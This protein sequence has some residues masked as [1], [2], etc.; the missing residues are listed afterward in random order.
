LTDSLGIDIFRCEFIGNNDH[1]RYFSLAIER[2]KAGTMFLRGLLAVVV[3]TT[4]VLASAG[5]V[6]E[7]TDAGAPDDETT[8]ALAPLSLGNPATAATLTTRSSAPKSVDSSEQQSP[9]PT[10]AYEIKIDVSR[11]D[12]MSAI[13]DKAG[14]P[15]KTAAS[16]I[17]AL[18]KVYNPTRLRQGQEITISFQTDAEAL[19]DTSSASS[20]EFLGLSL[21]PDF[22]HRVVVAKGEGGAFNASSQ[23]RILTSEPIRAANTISQSLYLAGNK[24]QVPNSVL[25]ELI[26][27]YSWDVDFQRDIRPND[28]F[29][30]MYERFSDVQGNP[31]YNGDVIFAALELSGKRHAIYRYT[32]PDGSVDYFDDQGK[33]ARKAL[34]RTPIDGARLSSGFGKRRH[35]ILGYTKMHKG[36]DFAA[37]RGTPI[38]AAGNGT[39]QYA[40]RKGAYGKFVLIRH[41]ADY[42]TAYAHMKRINTAKGRRVKQGQIIG[43][44]GTTGRSTG[45]H[46]HY[47]I[48]RSGRQVNPLRVKMPSGRKLKGNELAAFQIVR[49]EIDR[50]YAEQASPVKLVSR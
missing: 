45:P 44:V 13:L 14:V 15:R 16:A 20:G 7:R 17:T 26:R 9:S 32:L 35:P 11:G 46:L 30:L 39:V 37:P 48:R 50:Q 31:V 38:Y 47:E 2:R 29:E 40:G 49:G 42:S 22:R 6:M 27:L 19:S 1:E 4:G 8:L 36:L 43:Y 34:M 28:N 24:V 12:T 25:A 21:L 18:K 41:N 23:K 10:Q 5:F 3:L 33:S